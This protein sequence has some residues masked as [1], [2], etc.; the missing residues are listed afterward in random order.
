MRETQ[1]TVSW[2]ALQTTVGRFNLTISH[3]STF[4]SQL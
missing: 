3:Y 4:L 2:S 1:E